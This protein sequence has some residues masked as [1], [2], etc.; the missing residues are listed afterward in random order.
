MSKPAGSF[1]EDAD[2]SQWFHE[3]LGRLVRSPAVRSD[4]IVRHDISHGH[5]CNPHLV[6]NQLSAK[7]GGDI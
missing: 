5:T 6:K 3:S 2:S 7:A 4:K 1:D